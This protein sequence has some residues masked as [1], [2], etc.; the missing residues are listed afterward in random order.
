MGSVE[1]LSK[2]KKTLM[3]TQCS[4][5]QAGEGREPARGGGREGERG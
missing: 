5:C 2:E 4:D 3:D 1:G